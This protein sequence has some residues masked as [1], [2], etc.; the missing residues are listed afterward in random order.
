[1]RPTVLE[2]VLRPTVNPTVIGTTTVIPR[3][4]AGQAAPPTAAEAPP[5]RRGRKPRAKPRSES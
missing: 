2:P 5:A 3:G 1:V 4:A